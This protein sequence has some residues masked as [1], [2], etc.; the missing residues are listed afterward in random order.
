MT[1][2]ILT[3]TV[4]VDKIKM[5]QIP[6]PSAETLAAFR[7][8]GDP[9]GTVCDAMDELGISRGVIGANVLRPTMSGASIVGPALTVRNIP[10]RDDPNQLASG[11]SNKMGEFE[12]H[13]LAEP[14][15]VLVVQG[16]Q[17]VSNL[18]GISA[19][20]GKREGEIG[21]IVW[22]GIRDIPHLREIGYP[23][24]ASEFV[25]ATGKWRIETMEI[26]GPVQIVDVRVEPGD[27]V[28]ADDTSVCFVPLERIDDVL[29]VSLTKFEAEKAKTAA[30]EAGMPV[31][32]L[33]Q[34]GKKD[35]K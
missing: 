31:P 15:D 2:K 5:H 10:R 8:L 26:N 3:G 20:T 7:A 18:G 6:R 34:F 33:T 35:K 19:Q 4:S 23:A 1:K 24:W 32:E 12:A 29:K 30:I 28:V 9:V 21:A 25:A 11:K 22:G 27:L 14:G 16:V 13:N 17:N